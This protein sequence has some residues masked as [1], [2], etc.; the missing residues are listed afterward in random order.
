MSSPFPQAPGGGGMGQTQP[1][2]MSI[3]DVFNSAI[4]LM[5]ANRDQ[6]IFDSLATS[7]MGGN[8]F[9]TSTQNNIAQIGAQTGLAQDQMLTQLMYNQGQSD[10]DRAVQAAGMATP[11]S[12]AYDQMQQNRINQLAQ[13]GQWEQG[14]ADQL[15]QLPYQDWFQSRLGF[16]PQIMSMIG[17]IPM[18][19][20]QTPITTQTAGSPGLIDYAAQLAPYFM[21]MSDERLKTDIERHALGPLPGVPWASWVWKDTGTPSFGVIAQDL[22]SVRP[23]MVFE[24]S[25]VKHVDYGRL[26]GVT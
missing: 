18:P 1:G 20:Q 9:G 6:Q 8:R 13:M 10:A 14:R 11:F 5:N 25:G 19:Q 23:S 22:E 7:G 16:L 12:Q 15:Q 4:P 17:G 24:I 26:L 2:P 3:Y 21:M